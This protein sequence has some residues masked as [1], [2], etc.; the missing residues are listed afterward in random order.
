MEHGKGAVRDEIDNRD[1]KFGEIAMGSAPFDWSLGFDIE[2]KVG[3]IKVKDQNGSGSC[4]GQAWSYYGAVLEA[5][6][7]GSMEERSAKFIYS[8]TFVKPAGSAGRTNCDLVIK[9]GWGLESLTPSYNNGQAPDEAFMQR[10]QDITDEARKEALKAR[11]LVYSNVEPDIDLMAQACRD[12]GGLIIGIY[13]KNNGSW[14][15]PFPTPENTGPYWAHWLYVGKAK[16]INGKK[17]IAVLNSWGDVGDD[18]WQ[19]LS[20]DWFKHIPNYGV[21]IWYGW[22]LKFKPVDDQFHHTFTQTLRYSDINEEVKKLQ[23]VLYLEGVFT[24]QIDGRFGPITR[25]SVKAFQK[26]Y[27][28]FPDG[29]V[30]PKTRAKLNELYA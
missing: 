18:G 30:G 19:W 2:D 5:L 29:I 16:I 26:R 9:Q 1:L 25:S 21:L 4:G 10:P 3:K 8:Q 11:G 13:G 27:S 7:T 15:T 20:E 24:G 28:L 12:N 23:Y 17:Y 14:L 22:T 6:A